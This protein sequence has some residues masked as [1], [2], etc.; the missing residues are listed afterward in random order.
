M[1]ATAVDQ[2]GAVDFE[3]RGRVALAAASLA[4]LCS[5]P[6]TPLGVIS[7]AA[8][9]VSIAVGQLAAHVHLVSR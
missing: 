9:E 6:S 8:R 5:D 1:Q 4:R 3:Q 2:G 7:D